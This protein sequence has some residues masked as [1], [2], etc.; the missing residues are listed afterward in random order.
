MGDPYDLDFENPY[1]APTADLSAPVQEYGLAGTTYPLA[2][3]PWLTIWTRPRATIRH[4]VN[5]DPKRDVLLL[6]SLMGISS[7]LPS[8]LLS[9]VATSQIAVWVVVSLF[10]GPI[11]G[12]IALAINSEF[13]RY[14]GKWVGGKATREETKAAL[15]WTYVPIIANMAF[16]LPMA[17]FGLPIL[18][19]L[20]Q[21]VLGFW[22]GI[23]SIRA[24][25]EV[26]RIG[27]W[28]MFGGMILFSLAIMAIFLGVMGAVMLVFYGLSR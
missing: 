6:G 23:I 24:L 10:V 16:S 20:P 15:A 13:M 17:F 11:F 19:P 2:G 3:N 26:H 28:T 25:A 18:M 21:S 5:V 4:I 1:R 9:G 27:A 12:L 14:A 7:L 8:F 22:S